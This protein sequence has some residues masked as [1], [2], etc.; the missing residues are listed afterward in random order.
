MSPQLMADHPHSPRLDSTLVRPRRTI[1]RRSV[2]PA[3]DR[4]EPGAPR[5]TPEAPPPRPAARGDLAANQRGDRQR[6]GGPVRGADAV[7]DSDLPAAG[8][9]RAD[10]PH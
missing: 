9:R 4:S 5:T 3:A 8:A 1:L 7:G 6:G 10:L 2:P